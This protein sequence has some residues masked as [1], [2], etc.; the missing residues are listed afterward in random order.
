MVIAYTNS[1]KIR[2][3]IRIGVAISNRS[4]AGTIHQLH[5][6]IGSGRAVVVENNMNVQASQGDPLSAPS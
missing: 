1:T 4:T 2:L 6:Q 3:A 5:E